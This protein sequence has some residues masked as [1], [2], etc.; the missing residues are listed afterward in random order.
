MVKI[1][2]N[3]ASPPPEAPDRKGGLPHVGIYLLGKLVISKII[4]V[5]LEIS[6]FVAKLAFLLFVHHQ[7]RVR[8]ISQLEEIFVGGCDVY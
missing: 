4:L 7:F 6:T 1:L 5:E 2:L 3:V 8:D